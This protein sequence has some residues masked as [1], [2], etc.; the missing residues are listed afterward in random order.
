MSLPVEPAQDAIAA[1]HPRASAKPAR[2]SVRVAHIATSDA[3]LE[4]LLLHQLET[5]RAAGYDITGISAAGPGAAALT[6]A[7]VRH[8][9]V[10]M[11]RRYTPWG[12]LRCLLSLWRVLR[13]EDFDIVHTHTPKAG[14]LGQY[15]ALLAGVPLRVHTI[16]GLYFPG[17]MNP[18]ARFAYVLLE[19]ITMLFSHHNFSQNPEDTPVAI[20]EK[21]SRADRLE[22]IGNGI[23]LAAFDPALQPPAKRSRT[24]KSL[25]LTDEHLVVG[26]VARLV[27]EKGYFE[28]F[29]A[30]QL[31]L[32]REPRARFLF[33]GSFEPSKADAIQEGTLEQLGLQ[34]VA[35]FLGHRRDVPDLYAVMDVHVLPSHREGFPRSP[36]EASAMG[37]PSVVTDVRGCRQTVD[38]GQTGRIVPARSAEALATAIL[39]LLADP[40]LR[41]RFGEAARVKA[42]QEFD[43]QAVFRRVRNTYARL[44]THRSKG[45]P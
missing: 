14:L 28:M 16:H 43:E 23:D 30:A 1:R 35:Q 41:Q 18:R 3:S 6:S 32:E 44:L 13:R 2:A 29:R 45:A 22:L 26:V 27:A 34:D 37:I 42:K 8:I 9:S 15:A 12:D 25:G 21:I 20:K 39:E 17:H 4:L 19:R 5:L 36:M 40:E 38:D 10:P 24:R 7:G 33:I 11:S 31:V